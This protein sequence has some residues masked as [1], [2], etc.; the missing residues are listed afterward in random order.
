MGTV[1]TGPAQPDSEICWLTPRVR[2]KF[3]PELY[4]PARPAAA[5]P[6]SHDAGG[7]AAGE[8]PRE[9]GADRATKT[10]SAETDES[11]SMI[12]PAGF[13]Y[14]GNSASLSLVVALAG[15]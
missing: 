1:I 12:G 8:T 11:A 9:R 13:S 7:P 3:F 10:R 4:Q 14:G 5:R 15:R 6:V 2:G